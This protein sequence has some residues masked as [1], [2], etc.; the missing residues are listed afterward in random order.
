MQMLTGGT[1]PG[2]ILNLLQETSNEN[3]LVKE[4]IH[5]YCS[6]C[7]YKGRDVND[8]GYR[9]FKFSGWLTRIGNLSKVI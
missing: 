5:N 6:V 9:R 3:T 7:M 8:V 2:K 1:L 4:N